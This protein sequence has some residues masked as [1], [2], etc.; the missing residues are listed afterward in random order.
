MV[1]N[2]RLQILEARSRARI[3]S[4][5]RKFHRFAAKFARD[6]GDETFEF[7]LA[8][9]LARSFATSTRFVLDKSLA[10]AMYLRAR[11]L[12]ERAIEISPE[13]ANRFHLP[14][15]EIFID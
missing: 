14:V 10:R 12:I 11:Y 2:Y 15:E 5:A 7:R 9:G 1:S 3:L 6:T 4:V 8:F 13:N